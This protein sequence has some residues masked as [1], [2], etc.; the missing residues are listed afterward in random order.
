MERVGHFIVA[1]S[2]AFVFI[3]ILESFKIKLN[4]RNQ[5]TYM[6][7]YIRNLSFHQLND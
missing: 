4:N 2:S 7:Y 5:T 3:T 6:K 1:D